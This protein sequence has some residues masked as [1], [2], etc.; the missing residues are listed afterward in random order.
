VPAGQSAR[1]G[2]SWLRAWEPKVAV[3][4]ADSFVTPRHEK[5]VPATQPSSATKSIA[6]RYHGR[7][8]PV[9]NKL[10]R[11][12]ATQAGLT[13][14]ADESI[15]RRRASLLRPL[16]MTDTRDAP[17]LFA[18]AD[19]AASTVTA[20]YERGG[21]PVGDRSQAAL[22]RFDRAQVGHLCQR[23]ECV[24]RR[25]ARSKRPA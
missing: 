8:D 16:P 24:P 17:P 25:L 10:L 2:R 15:V 6:D 9:A 19:H 11:E 12:N 20:T 23:L 1:T 7:N 14:P 22:T 5:P 13:P 3:A 4:G 18:S 21:R